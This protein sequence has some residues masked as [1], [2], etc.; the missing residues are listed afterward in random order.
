MALRRVTGQED[1]SL[2]AENNVEDENETGVSI[3]LHAAIF[4]HILTH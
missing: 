1:G 3:F 2:E 4:T